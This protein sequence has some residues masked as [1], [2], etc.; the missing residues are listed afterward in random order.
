MEI[1]P[2]STA[3]RDFRRARRKA[4]LGEVLARLMGRPI[5]L[6]SF[7]EVSQRLPIEETGK[8]SLQEIPLDTIVGSVGRYKDFTRKFLPRFE[9]DKER[10]ARV[11]ISVDSMGLQPI[12]VYQVGQVY[13]V[14][15]GH[16]R[17]SVAR[18]IGAQTILAN[19]IEVHSKVPLTPDDRLDDLIIKAEYANFLE[20]THLDQLRPDADIKVTAPGS[21]QLIERQIQ[22]CSSILNQEQDLEIVYE[23]AVTRWYDEIYTPVVRVIRERGIL[24]EF[25]GRTET[26]LYLWISKHRQM[27]EDELDW[28]IDSETASV[29]LVDQFSSKPQRVISRV[30]ERLL[31][32]LLPDKLEAGPPPGL[33]RQ[34]RVTKRQVDRLFNNILV[35]ISGSDTGWCALEQALVV[36]KREG[37]RVSGLHVA[38]SKAKLKPQVAEALKAEFNQICESAGVQGKMAFEFGQI[39]RKVCER[40]RWVDLVVLRINHPPAPQPISR[41]SSGLSTILR[42]CPR[43]ILAVPGTTTN[44]QRLLLAYDGSP[45]AD[46]ALFVAAYMS[47]WW[48]AELVVVNIQQPG[49][50]SNQV[51]S[52]AR[53]Y[54]GNQ[55]SQAI[56][57]RRGGSV[58]GGILSATEEY[59]CDL[60]IMGGYGFNP[61]V[62]IVLGSA[63]DE[64]L[65]TSRKPLLICR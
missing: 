30:S 26:D 23:Q 27:L 17:V 4:D 60:I 49:P 22:V 24:R 20:H 52:R 15:D 12:D 10:W 44:L 64:V 36:A 16:H 56:Y 43:P 14:L 6:L 45:K 2:I 40:A 57:A 19:V 38:S 13:F 62:E 55:G 5:S 46:E 7:D 1:E 54:L 59:D 47:A 63:V 21:Y 65:R 34:Q 28:R 61:F 42:R 31:D 8:R 39:P 32:A 18:Q 3:S 35:A 50:E 48:N 51:L 11:K 53:T 25:P 29:D 9:S 58:A 41:L 37:T 33:W